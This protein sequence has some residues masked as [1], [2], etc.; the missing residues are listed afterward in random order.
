MAAARRSKPRARAR[1]K[2]SSP[3]LP[4]L[5]QHHLDL[6]GLGLVALSVF[7]GFVL[8]AG[9]GAHPGRAGSAL[10]DG[11]GWAVGEVRF[12]APPAFAAAGAILVLRPVL[13]A[14]RPFRSGALCLFSALT[15]ALA[16]GTL[17]IGPSGARSGYWN[18]PFFELRGGIVGDALLYAT[19]TAV[20]TIGAHILAVFLFVA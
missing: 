19:A 1:A 12:L 3:S 18:T 6:L 11:L 9:H 5:E 8:Y 16:A 15:L 7:L 14:V 13:P 17:G 2:R 20:S 10:I 4:V